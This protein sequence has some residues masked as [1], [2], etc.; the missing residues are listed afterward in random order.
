MKTT[1]SSPHPYPYTRTEECSWQ[2]EEVA[3][4]LASLASGGSAP[5][6]TDSAQLL[7]HGW[8]SR[9][10]AY[11]RSTYGSNVIGEDSKKPKPNLLFQ[12]IPF[13]QPV[14]SA[15]LEQ[16]KEPLILMLL[17]SA[18]LSIALGN[19]ADAISIGIALLIVSLVAAIQE[20]RSEQALEKLANLVP[21]MCTVLR[22]GRVLDSFPAKELVVGDLVL[23]S[24]GDKVPADCRVVD[25]VELRVDESSLTG[26]NH[27]V[28]KTGEGL[29]V[30]T[31]PPVTQQVNVVFA[32]TLVNAGRGRALVLAVGDQTEFGMVA[33][34]LGS[35]TTRKSPLQN[36]IDELG[37]RLAYLSSAAIAMIAI[38]GLLMGRPFLETVTVAVSLAVAAI[39]EGLP[40]CTTVTLALG[41]LRMSKRNAI[42]KKLPV[43]ESLGCATVV[44]SDKTGTLTQN[45]MTGR[46]VFTLAFP[47][48]KFGFT[49]VGYE[50]MAG[51][52]M[53]SP[54]G[55]SPPTSRAVESSS[56][57]YAAIAALFQTA[58]LCNNATV[59]SDLDSDLSEGH[60]GGAMSGQP[61]ELA[62]LVGA[63]KANVP[64]PRPQYHRIQEIPFSSE[65]KRMEVRAR[66]VSGIHC[67]RAFEMATL[68][69]SATANPSPRR[70]SSDGSLYFL[71]GMPESILAECTSH[72]GPD[73]SAVPL[74][75]DHKTLVLT[76][77][78]RMAAS[79]L[80]VLAMSYGASLD[81]LTF[82]GVVG[83]EDPPR[84]GVAE[85]VWKLRHGGVRVM[86]V[87]GDSKET[88]LAIARRCGIV[89]TEAEHQVLVKKYSTDS[90]SDLN[91]GSSESFGMADVELGTSMS[92]SGEDLDSIPP[93]N[94]AE[95]IA[96]VK[97][98]YRVAPRH[99]L[100]IVRALQEHGDIVA[101][102]G[103]GE[104]DC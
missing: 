74:D 46:A 64:D 63:E 85:S 17:F 36:K 80:R 52:L 75:E 95:S 42:I 69:A 86:M 65:R 10:V 89:G 35:V 100:A 1:T 81:Q 94:L 102:T 72:T 6:I 40:I 8:S 104:Y 9:Q 97:V 24:T 62:L 22:D 16:L 21:H 19:A 47:H 59:V 50:A 49:G 20:Y 31:A 29:A 53:A 13:L 66:P 70:K 90:L 3:R 5:P 82:A 18:V 71:K 96:D 34:E 26:E 33:T 12:A 43:V 30:G 57:E 88:A 39:P 101:M 56:D 103:D 28:S 67:C 44:A 92:L 25:S 99:K 11:L 54:A 14:L 87:T 91:G 58:C 77:S 27:P 93:Q 68:S 7:H 48:K 15:L 73:G 4:H 45:E 51:K 98:F 55:F 61:T 41:V 2:P 32:G 60:S 83:M 23:L 37:K 84:D 78:R 76:H 38:L 79:G